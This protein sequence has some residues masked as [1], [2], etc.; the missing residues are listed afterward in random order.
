[1]N[2]AVKSV[3]VE[4]NVSM[5]EVL[6]VVSKDVENAIGEFRK[7][8]R[9]A[10]SVESLE[11]VKRVMWDGLLS[12]GGCYYDMCKRCPMLNVLRLNAYIRYSE[13]LKKVRLQDLECN[14]FIVV[15]HRVSSYVAPPI[16]CCSV[17]DDELICNE[18][19][20]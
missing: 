20:Y 12:E 1:M 7:E 16:E 6:K 3:C 10:K 11:F 15:N 19:I 2:K 18:I 4:F 14:E 17:L 8:I 9:F 13:V 5:E